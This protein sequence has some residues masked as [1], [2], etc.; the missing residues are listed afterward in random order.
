V[1]QHQRD[2]LALSPMRSAVTAWRVTARGYRVRP[3]PGHGPGGLTIAPPLRDSGYE[4]PRLCP[5][6][7]L[8][9]AEAGAQVTSLTFPQAAG[10][11]RCQSSLTPRAAAF[12]F[13][14]F[15]CARVEIGL[16][17]CSTARS[18]SP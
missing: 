10:G 4:F 8:P 2:L 9:G 16:A 6:N 5:L 7:W 17:P 11:P 3:T 18:R 1:T 15:F 12:S 14:L 13:S